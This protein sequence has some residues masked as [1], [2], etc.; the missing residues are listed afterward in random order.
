MR[1]R[2]FNF[3]VYEFPSMVLKDQ[4]GFDTYGS[5]SDTSTMVTFIDAIPNGSMVLICSIDSVEASMTATAWNKLV[6]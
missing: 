2:G 1:G 6:S 4:Q 5:S 3:G